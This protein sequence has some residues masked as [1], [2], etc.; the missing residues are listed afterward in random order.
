MSYKI[1]TETPHLCLVCGKPNARI[2]GYGCGGG[3]IRV[4]TECP[5]CKAIGEI[6]NMNPWYGTELPIDKLKAMFTLAGFTILGEPL[7]LQNRYWH[8]NEKA[9]YHPW[10][11][12]RTAYGW[13]EIG[14]RKRV[15]S[16]DWTH[17]TVRHVVTTDE[18][19]KGD[20][21]V[22]AYSEAKA[23]EYL[24]ELHRFAAGNTQ[25]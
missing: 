24:T 6:T 8:G 17:T 1:D 14:W 7:K 18:L 25:G 21:H 19:T 2:S 16:I 12:V 11:F 3:G 15:M 9:Y 4:D 20:D 10:W 13:I 5:D 22:H 23:I